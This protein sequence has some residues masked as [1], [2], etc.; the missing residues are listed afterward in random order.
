MTDAMRIDREAADWVAKF[1]RRQIEADGNAVEAFGQA[2]EGFADWVSAS[3]ENRTAFLRAHAAWCRA[4]RLA[5]LTLANRAAAL[6]PR[7]VKP[8]WIAAAAACFALIA[9]VVIIQLGLPVGPQSYETA[10]G[11]RETV[12]LAD[13]SRLELNTNT[14]LTANISDDVRNVTLEKG[15]VYFDIAH[16]ETRPFVI[17]AG[18]SRITV[19]G[20]KFTVRRDGAD[21][22]VIVEEGKVRIDELGGGVAV[23]PTI[24]EKDTIVFARATGTLIV[25][26]TDAQL[27]AELGWRRGLL[28]FDQMDLE[29]VAAEF[30]RYNRVKIEVADADA[31]AIR[32]GG[33]FE[34][35]NVDAFVRLLKDGFGLKI[36]RRE[37]IIVIK[38]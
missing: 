30:N 17:D 27:N 10:L 35:E 34:A 18:G 19:L 21:V 32:I 14:R 8:A 37:N 16:D 5:A 7:V 22:E 6:E 12:P 29:A 11:G 33:S 38:S 31:A 1:D 25:A 15:E 24:V 28:I 23:A 2:D 20:T 26:K 3:F 13:G 36:E 9:T 4:D